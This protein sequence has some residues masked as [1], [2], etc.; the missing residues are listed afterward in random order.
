M[1]PQLL[2][3][4]CCQDGQLLALDF[5]QERAERSA[6]KLGFKEHI[7]LETLTVPAFARRGR[8]K[9]RVLYRQTIE[10]ATFTPY[11]IRPV[12]RL[13][14][15][16]ADHIEYNCKYADRTAITEA[17]QKRGLADDILM[18]KNGHLTDT[19]YANIA[20]WDGRRWLT[21]ALPMLEGT[22]R[23]RLLQQQRI[24]PANIPSQAVYQFKKIVLFNA[25]MDLESGPVI[26][27]GKHTLV[28]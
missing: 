25:M 13:K 28:V 16:P 17:F 2:E 6:N 24:Q 26:P 11:T 8:F 9:C 23:A 10:A 19:S 12:R 5:H 18:V 15:T 22:R 1:M 4:I 20:L 21:P 7:N 3:T 14:L 27:V